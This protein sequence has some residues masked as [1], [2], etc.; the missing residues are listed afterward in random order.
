LIYGVPVPHAGYFFGTSQ[1]QALTGA[2]SITF[3]FWVGLPAILFDRTFGLAG[4]APWICIAVIGA[5][6]ALRA[7]PRALAPAAAAIVTSLLALS[8]Y[9]YWE[10]GYAP[11]NRYF[12]EVLPLTAPFVAYGLAAAR[13]WWMRALVGLL[14]GM[15]AFA[16]FLLS[17]MPAR[18][19]NDASRAQ[20]QDLVDIALGLIAMVWLPSFIPVIPHWGLRASLAV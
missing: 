14:I 3:Q 11:P 7:A 6:P 9:R 4:S 10:G 13:D 8:L 2:P 5:V 12:V 1:A 20:L 16:A 17:A 18:P 19:P 15:S